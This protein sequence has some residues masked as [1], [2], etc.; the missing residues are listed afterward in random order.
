MK[1]LLFILFALVT[2]TGCTQAQ[3]A[4]SDEKSNPQIQKL[5]P[6]RILNTDSVYVTPAQ[7]KKNKPVMLIYFSPDCSHCQHM[8]YEMQPKM[9]ELANVQ[10]VMITFTSYPMIK[11]FYRDFG[12]SR[13]PN[14]TI[15][16]EGYTYKVQQY[17]K[18]KTTPYI[19]I[20]DA[21]GKLVK[22][23]EKPPKIEELIKVVKK[24]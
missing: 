24:A 9:K 18:V 8:M 15:G 17:Y 7:L 2:I 23:Y 1:K 14:I 5:A 4:Q 22:T 19:A 3:N 12:I 10:I 13:Y 21:K 20:Y 11:A 6:Y 16:T